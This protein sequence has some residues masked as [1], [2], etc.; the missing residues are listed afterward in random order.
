MSKAW[1]FTAGR[2]DGGTPRP[3]AAG[4][5]TWR[6][7]G[8]LRSSLAR[9]C[10]LTML[11]AYVAGVY[12]VI[13]VGLGALFPWSADW[14]RAL[15][16]AAVVVTAG[17]FTS[18]RHRVDAV[19]N[20]FFVPAA[21]P[22]EILAH[23]ADQLGSAGS[24]EEA[25]PG[26]A[27]LVGEGT[28]ALLAAVWLSTGG[29]FVRAAT[30]PA[31]PDPGGSASAASY[32]LLAARDDVNLLSGVRDG[33]ELLGALTV[34][35]PE[36][37][38]AVPLDIRLMAD[39][40]NSAGFLLRNT[41]LTAELA[42]RLRSVS[43][44][45]D[46]RRASR[47]RLV[48]ARDIARRRLAQEITAGV[49]DPLDAMRGQIAALRPL[50]AA[51]GGAQQARAF[52]AAAQSE[53]D[54]LVARFRSIVHGIYPPVLSDHGLI[55][56]LESLAATLP[57]VTRVEG[58]ELPRYPMDVE[59]TVYFCAAAA[60]RALAARD[61]GTPLRIRL[62]AT[63]PDLVLTVTDESRSAGLADDE[64]AMLEE[65]NDRAGALDGTVQ[66]AADDGG[67]RVRATVPLA[68]PD[69]G[70]AAAGG[71]EEQP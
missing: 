26:L 41:L 2:R 20:R 18:V 32:E 54:S 40:A 11:A 55:A 70:L 21:R 57:R 3:R 53:I 9:T 36:G 67:L 7:R 51:D 48:A 15:G 66:A 37:R 38:F 23:I 5:G 64:L 39:L 46:E 30:W 33:G 45:A 59:S 44:Q 68:G 10:R 61:G 58:D 63:A 42:E 27:R 31:S 28:A 24:L 71:G 56:A 22:Y 17:G 43:A 1:W 13:V 16:L 65:L 52:I 49:R 34:A 69:P 14:R 25:L 29:G 62:A 12:L 50:A 19:V 35:L 4:Q 60:A 8:P 6:S 47:R